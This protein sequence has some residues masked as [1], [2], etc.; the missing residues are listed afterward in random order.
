MAED[1]TAAAYARALLTVAEAEGTLDR[2][3]N[4]LYRFS[5]LLDGNAELRDR[6]TDPAVELPVKLE[7]VD[8]L[9]G[10]YPETASAV[11]WLVQSGRGRE[12]HAVAD[13]FVRQAAAA[14]GTSVAEVRT[15]RPLDEAQQQRL[16]QAISAQVGRPVELRVVDDPEVVGGIVV[17][18][19]DEVIDGSVARRLAELRAALTGA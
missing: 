9:I 7:I 4:G 1:T 16:A 14:R 19:G 15:A 17:K 2:Q 18:I 11:M 5:R 10:G 8:E 6:L 12:I 13:E 3:E